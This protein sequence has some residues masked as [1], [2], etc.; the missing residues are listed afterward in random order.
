MTLGRFLGGRV[1][2]R[3][4]PERLLAGAFA[5]SGVGLLILWTTSN[6]VVMMILLVV[7]G[8]GVALQ[9]PLAIGRSIR[10]APALSDRASGTAIVAAGLSIMVAPFALGAM[11]DAWGLRTAFLVVPVL[12]ALGVA[13]VLFRPVPALPTGQSTTT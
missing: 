4:D 12:A 2:E 5:V 11:A 6:P 3:V 13:L 9:W 7:I 10:C 8:L 1:A